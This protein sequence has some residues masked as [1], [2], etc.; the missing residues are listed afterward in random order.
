MRLHLPTKICFSALTLTGLSINASAQ[1]DAAGAS[2]GLVSPNVHDFATISEGKTLPEKVLRARFVYG[3]VN[4]NGSAFDKD[5]KKQSSVVDVKA[6]GG[7]IVAEYGLSDKISLQF[8]QDYTAAYEVTA[9]TSSSAY[10]DVKSAAFA[11][12]TGG[13]KNATE[14][15]QGLAAKLANS[16]DFRAGFCGGADE[17]TCLQSILAGTTK[18]TTGAEFTTKSIPGLKVPN[19]ATFKAELDGYAN[20]KDQQI[21][22]AISNAVKKEGGKGLGDTTIG[23]LYSAYATEAFDASIGAGIRYPSGNRDRSLGEQKVGRGLTETGVRV[24]LDYLPVSI[25]RLSYQNISEV[26]LASGKYKLGGSNVTVKRNGVRNRGF[27]IVKPS[28]AAI[29]PSL[30]FVAP[31]LGLSYDAD[32]EEVLKIGD[33]EE[34]S[35]GARGYQANWYG[36]IAASFFEFGVPL[37]FEVEYQKAAMGKNIAAATDA[38]TLQLKGFYKF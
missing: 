9:N 34:A 20:V 25:V 31:K 2:A 6:A 29:T 22:D 21:S 13:A 38:L 16:A 35:Q 26:M 27:F 14:L 28:L 8:Q 1:T 18:N 37:Q 7:A 24:N 4:G 30:A 19:G 5:G 15:S 10:G 11:S 3:T 17:T 23:F 12:V 36:G 33:A 32:S